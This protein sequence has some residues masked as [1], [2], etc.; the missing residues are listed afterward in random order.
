MMISNG[1]TLWKLKFLNYIQTH[2]SSNQATINRNRVRT[3]ERQKKINLKTV[4][5][6]PPNEEP[7]KMGKAK[8]KDL[9]SLCQGVTLVV[10][11]AEYRDFYA[12]L[13]HTDN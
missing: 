11:I 12:S 7:N 9:M 1:M 8:Y 13:P 4:I 3:L 2:C 5:L 10:K 6:R